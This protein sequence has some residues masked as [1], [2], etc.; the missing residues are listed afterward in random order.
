M[1]ID[2][3]TII[4]FVSIIN[5]LLAAGFILQYIMNKTYRGIAWW[6]AGSLM[7]ALGF[8][9]ILF[10]D[11]VSVSLIS[12]VFANTILLS[13]HIFLYIGTMRF[14]EKKEKLSII[15]FIF[16]IF[17]FLTLYFVYIH[18]NDNLRPV[19]LYVPAAIISFFIFHGLFNTHI[20]SVRI[21]AKFTAGIFFI[22]GCFFAAR[23]VLAVIYFPV[24]YIFTSSLTQIAV[25]TSTIIANTLGTF[26]F[27]I[28]FNQRLIADSR[29]HRENF[30]LLFYESPD[31]AVISRLHDGIVIN[32]NEGYTALFGYTP[33]DIIG[34]TTREMNLWY[35]PADRQKIVDELKEKGCSYK[36]ESLFRKKDGS[37]VYGITSARLISLQ[38]ALHVLSIT[39]DINERR[40]MEEALRESE[41]KYRLLIENSHD[42]IY[43][44]SSEG[45]IT[46]LSPS[47][48]ALLGY[49]PS[50]YTGKSFEILIHPDD[51]HKCSEWMQDIIRTGH[52]G[53][54]NIE[55]R[56]RHTDGSWR[57]HTSNAMPVRNKNGKITGIQGTG[58]DITHTKEDAEKIKSL[59]AEKEL[60]LREVH[61]RI[62]NNMNSIKLLLLIQADACHDVSTVSALQDA[63]SRIDSMI[64]LYKSLYEANYFSDLP[65]KDHIRSLAGLIIS[66]FPNSRRITLEQDIDEFILNVKI[67]QPL[68][69]IINELLTNIMKYAFPDGAAGVI[70]LSLKLR[71]SKVSLVVQDNGIGIPEPVDFK[72][73]TSFGME[74]VSM[75]TEQLKGN[76]RIERGNGTK[77]ILEFMKE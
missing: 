76:I 47:M 67:L 37:F 61:H 32:I 5:I 71:D 63:A 77:I 75:L 50:D 4:V 8:I 41:G 54:D 24:E 6:A 72:N 64:V 48:T 65:V 73:F 14:L 7:L 52:M 74:L 62:K 30:E 2:I 27:I 31:A 70:R 33:G 58:R 69:I 10:R 34:R 55:Y 40:H 28:M 29:E 35:D 19:I 15:T 9:L 26:G 3:R 66:H 21:T 43:T 45:I 25:F 38:G 23:S 16:V 46:F 56:V 18:R 20:S 13:G 60:I 39:H 12:I 59:L 68:G 44:L 1:N 22:Y 53:M 11:I 42:I 49:A 57:W 36:T 17:I 51:I